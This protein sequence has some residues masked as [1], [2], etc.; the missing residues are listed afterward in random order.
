MATIF[1]K[2]MDALKLRVEWE[3]RLATIYKMRRVGLRRKTKPFPG[4][5]DMHYPL[6]DSIIEKQKPY[7]Y[8]QIFNPTKLAT[9][10]SWRA[11]Q[12]GESVDASERYFDFK[13]RH[14]SNLPKES[15]ILADKVLE[16]GNCILKVF[17]NE[18]ESQLQFEAIDPLYFIVP[19]ATKAIEDADF[20][21]QVH[22][23]TPDAYRA[24]KNFKQDDDLVKQI[25]GQDG[26]NSNQKEQIKYLR[27]GI[28]RPKTEM[29]IVWEIWE[30]NHE[31]DDYTVTWL[32][33]SKPDIELRKLKGNP[34]QH[35]KLP[36]VNF[37]IEL[38]DPEYYAPRGVVTRVAPFQ[39][40]LAKN[41]N[42]KLDCMTYYNRPIYTTDKPNAEVNNIK[43]MP[44]QIIG[45][46]ITRV[47]SGA[48]PISFDQEMNGTRMVA[49]SM[50]GSPDYMS[51]QQINT[52][53]RRTKYELQQVVS[54]GDGI[55]SLRGT[56]F[57]MWLQQVYQLAWGL[58][59]QY[60]KDYNFLFDNEIGELATDA[61]HADY[62]IQPNGNFEIADKQQQ[63]NLGSSLFQNLK[64]DP[65]IDQGELR[66]ILLESVAPRYAKRLY[67]DANT[68][69]A[70]QM[71]D[72]AIEL[73]PLYA[74]Y[75]MSVKP[76]DD[77][78]AHLHV[79]FGWLEKQHTTG[80][81][82]DML[83]LS[84]V[85][86]H[87]VCHAV[88]LKKKQPQAWQQLMASPQ[89]QAIQQW[90]QQLMQAQQQQQ[91]GQQQQP[92]M[93]GAPQ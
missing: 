92:T 13:V 45:G 42:E 56:T 37:P 34:Y 93:A 33:P 80:Q 3:N 25:T 16:N 47:E 57:A 30:K 63:A 79:I 41:W 67:R 6:A 86:E 75:P 77:D 17:W 87:A 66:Q 27:E 48:P 44:G 35:G 21:V 24:N 23:Y 19:A 4:A 52:G 65:F 1:D 7:L 71:E 89:G 76:S 54:T 64:D 69:A 38:I 61:L 14:R 60:D 50:I 5:A 40:S 88:Q 59:C 72:Q 84:R 18:K 51:G 2:V 32:S 68:Q 29:I 31:T 53:E 8:N 49:E 83:G 20:V 12:A 28:N 91:Q 62:T 55:T 58:L 78:Q 73:G 39:A 22:Q 85:Q 10:A 11:D 26:Q 90:Q 81:K 36:F 70:T 82:P 74:G 43:L 9:F 46:N 15:L